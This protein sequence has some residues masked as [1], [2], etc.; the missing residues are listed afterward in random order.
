M[1]K[2]VLTALGILMLSLPLKA[3]ET[4]KAELY[5][6]YSLLRLEGTN[7]NGWNVS[8]AGVLNRHLAVVFDFSGQYGSDKEQIGASTIR[9][10]F[11]A[12][13]FLVGPRVSETV[14]RWTPYAHALAGI[15]RLSV[16]SDI[17]SPTGVTT[18]SSKSDVSFGMALGGGLDYQAG[19]S[20]TLRLIQADYFIARPDRFKD[21]GARVGAGIVIRIGRKTP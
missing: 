18:S 17:V 10:D 4:P 20:V 13:S 1:R 15:T 2:V 16:D 7:L 5:W 14:G 21:E 6:G 8:V 19:A 12:H 11:N 9:S 3:Q